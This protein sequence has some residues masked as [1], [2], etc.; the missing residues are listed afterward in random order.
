MS[1]CTNPSDP[2]IADI[3]FCKALRWRVHDPDE[4]RHIAASHRNHAIRFRSGHPG[5][6]PQAARHDQMAAICEEHATALNAGRS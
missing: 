5:W 1:V 2:E 6:E 4:A 3:W